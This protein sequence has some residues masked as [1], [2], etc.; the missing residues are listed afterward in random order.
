VTDGL[1]EGE[2]A[3]LHVMGIQ[4]ASKKRPNPWTRLPQPRSIRR[5]RP[6]DLSDRSRL[7]APTGRRVRVSTPLGREV[8]DGTA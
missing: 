2:E 4:I 7:R 8:L 5:L 6:P 3:V 1:F